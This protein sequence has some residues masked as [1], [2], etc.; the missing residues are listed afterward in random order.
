MAR[1][2]GGAEVQG[3]VGSAPALVTRAHSAC[4]V[5]VQTAPTYMNKIKIN[6]ILKV[7]LYAS[8]PLYTVAVQ[9]A[10]VRQNHIKDNSR[11]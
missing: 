10:P 2:G 11:G 3:A 5:A 4:T 7:I 8:P 1:A 9:T 6:K